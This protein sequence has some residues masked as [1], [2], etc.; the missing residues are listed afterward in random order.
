MLQ[1]GDPVW[2]RAG[3]LKLPGRQVAGSPGEGRPGFEQGGW[4]PGPG[5]ERS[6]GLAGCH[7]SPDAQNS[8]VLPPVTSL[9]GFESSLDQP[10]LASSFLSSPPLDSLFFC[11]L[12]S[13]PFRCPSEIKLCSVWTHWTEVQAWPREPGWAHRLSRTQVPS[14]GAPSLLPGRGA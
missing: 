4:T 12:L 6:P 8:A 9:L 11:S 7:C 2:G 10:C 13:C 1:P 14:R 5:E 3:E